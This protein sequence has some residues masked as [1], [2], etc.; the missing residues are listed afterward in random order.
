LEK[1]SIFGK[2]NGYIQFDDRLRQRRWFKEIVKGEKVSKSYLS[3]VERECKNS[4]IQGT[5]AYMMK[6][7]LVNIYRYIVE[8]N[9]RSLIINTVYDE[10]IVEVWEGEEEHVQ[11][12]EKI[13]KDAG[14]YFLDG[15]EMEVE[16]NLGKFWSK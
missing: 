8:N 5:N 12:F 7:A 11:H 15:I 14:S 1:V 3:S 13:M 4:P 16:G 10:M 9:L 6:L 2:E